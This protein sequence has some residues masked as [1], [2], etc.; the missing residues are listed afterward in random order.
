M[1]AKGGK[2]RLWRQMVSPTEKHSAEGGVPKG[3]LFPEEGMLA[4]AA[5]GWGLRAVLTN[6]REQWLPFPSAWR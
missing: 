1:T 4:R 5:G 3:V 6:L 2:E